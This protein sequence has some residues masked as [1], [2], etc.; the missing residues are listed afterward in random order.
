MGSDGSPGAGGIVGIT[1]ALD[2]AARKHAHQRR[3][4]IRAE[5]YINHLTEVALLLAEATGGA[6]APLVMAGLLH[7]TIED[8]ETTMEELQAEFGPD[9]AG[10]VAEVTDDKR[11]PRDERK[12]LQVQSAP[13]RSPRARMI[14]LADKTANLHSIHVSPPVGWSSRRKREYVAWAR[15]VA[16]A[17][18]PTNERL[19]AAFEAAARELEEGM[20]PG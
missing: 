10:L 8:T 20:G 9:V 16:A 13:R 18:G 12:R 19:E 6:D 11:L 4:G 15:E 1:R 5:P 7:D 3:K 17:C 2:F 14:K